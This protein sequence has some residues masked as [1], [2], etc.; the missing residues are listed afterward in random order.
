AH[1]RLEPGRELPVEHACRTHLRLEPVQPHAKAEIRA[2]LRLE[3]RP[4][5]HAA[6]QCQVLPDLGGVGFEPA[7][8]VRAIA[9]A[10]L[11]VE[12]QVGAGAG[13]PGRALERRGLS[14]PY[15]APAHVG[16]ERLIGFYLALCAYG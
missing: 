14:P 3:H 13:T 6:G 9:V 7:V 2:K 1:Q 10:D 11:E 12:A 16:R 15:G 4:D 5:A 8:G